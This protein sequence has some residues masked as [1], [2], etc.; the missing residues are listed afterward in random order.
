MRLAG[1]LLLGVAAAGSGRLL[2]QA[3][4]FDV[5]SIK[6]NITVG[7]SAIQVNPNGRFTA[8]NTSLRALI[9]RAFG[10]HD[11]QL[12]GAPGWIATERFD[13][14]ARTETPLPTGPEAM[15]PML[16]T[17]LTE[18]FR[19]RTHTEMRELPA[20]VLRFARRDR[21]PGPLIR[22][23]QADCSGAQQPTAAEIRAQARDGW[24]PCGIA[25]MVSFVDSSGNDL[26]TR[27]RR[28]A[29]AMKDFATTLQ[30]NVG[31]PVVDRTGLDGRF[32]LEYSFAQQ[33][34]SS[35]AGGPD[36]NQPALLV[37]LQ[38]QLGLKLESQR[39]AVPV[40]VIDSVEPLIEN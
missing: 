5:A 35:A 2:A 3:P 4:A 10:L 37:A 11:S 31:R 34:A 26:K 20:F 6:P 36:S 1:V 29:I 40:L 25:F 17:L 18:R 13:V 16:R 8:T 22:T 28:S 15:M 27:I 39:T 23:T 33:P 9:L 38:E 7:N 21:R 30:T 32:D 24:P 14:N 12:I 19:L